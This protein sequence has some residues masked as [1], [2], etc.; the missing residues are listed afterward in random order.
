V[1]RRGLVTV[2]VLAAPAIG[3]ILTHG[4][5]ILAIATEKFSSVIPL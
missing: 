1:Y 2:G 5:F 4:Q 3:A